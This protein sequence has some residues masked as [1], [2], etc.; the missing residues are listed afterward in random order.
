MLV[1]C[2]CPRNDIK[3][4]ITVKIQET[5]ND[6][7]GNMMSL[8]GEHNQLVMYKAKCTGKVQEKDDE[9][10][11]FFGASLMSNVTTLVCSKQLGIL[12]IGIPLF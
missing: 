7:A 6:F 5:L 4:E 9:V 12:G 3:P 10:T 8:E 11:F 2:A 1:L